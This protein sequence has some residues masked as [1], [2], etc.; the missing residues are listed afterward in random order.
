MHKQYFITDPHFGHHNILKFTD[1]NGKLTRE[2]NSIEEMDDLI[3]EN[4]NK[5]VR[6]VDKLYILGDCAMYR[7]CLSTLD[8]INTKKRIL[9]RGNHDIFKLKDY[10]PYFKD[11]RAY[12]IMP[13]HGLIFSHIPIHPCQLEGRFVLNIDGHRH[14]NEIDDKRY[15]NIC[16]EIIG[17]HPIDLETILE[18]KNE[19]G[20]NANNKE[21]ND[22]QE[23]NWENEGGITK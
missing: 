18:V 7:R 1:D 16:P 5:V 14:Q 21:N 20:L 13:K 9:I 17:Y 19:R 6:V 2:F 15:M 10:T 8:R 11:V 22:Y 4:I 3:I 12:K 23:E